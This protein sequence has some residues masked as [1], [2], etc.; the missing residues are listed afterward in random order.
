MLA[1]TSEHLN[2]DFGRLFDEMLK[3]R[4]DR[5]SAEPEDTEALVEA[6][7]G[8]A[9]GQMLLDRIHTG[10]QG[11]RDTLAGHPGVEVLVEGELGSG[12]GAT[13][14]ASLL[15]TDV[16]SLIEGKE[17]LLEEWFGLTP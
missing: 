3:R 12:E 13:A 14:A 11:M 10:H 16:A 5:L 17:T 7:S 9:P 15:R 4:T 2:D 1:E 6:V 8:T